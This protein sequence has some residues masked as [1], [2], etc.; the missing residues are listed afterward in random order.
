MPLN[1]YALVG[2]FSVVSAVSGVAAW[3]VIG[4]PPRLAAAPPVAVSFLALYVV[5]HRLGL[6]I[7]PTVGLFGFE[8]ALAFDL[9]V[10]AGSAAAT[11]AVER[12]V[13]RVASQ[14]RRSSSLERS[15]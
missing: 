9:G 10:A 6:S 15:G 11:A 2:F 3:R 12:V 4:P 7:G 5:G 14:G 1:A 8:V 13:W